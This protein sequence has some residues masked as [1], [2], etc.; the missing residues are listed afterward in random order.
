MAK[1]LELGARYKFDERKL[2]ADQ[3]SKGIDI[4]V[5]AAQ[6]KQIM[7]EKMAS[8]VLDIRSKNDASESKSNNKKAK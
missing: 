4:S 6:H 8:K 1:G 7:A 3:V 2:K 5:R